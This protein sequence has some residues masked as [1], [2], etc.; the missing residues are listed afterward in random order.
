LYFPDFAT[1]SGSYAARVGEVAAVE[2]VAE[3]AISV[4]GIEIPGYLR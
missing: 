2:T 4:P 3:A 1:T